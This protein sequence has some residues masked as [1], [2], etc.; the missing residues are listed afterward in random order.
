MTPDKQMKKNT[1]KFPVRG[2]VLFLYK[3]VSLLYFQTFS[4]QEV[5]VHFAISLYHDKLWVFLS[6]F[7]LSG[8]L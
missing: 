8:E 3:E 5:Y 6:V 4:G 7:F 2:N 1:V